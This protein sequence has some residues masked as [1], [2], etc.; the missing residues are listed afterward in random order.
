MKRRRVN[1]FIRPHII[2]PQDQYTYQLIRDEKDPNMGDIRA[3]PLRGYNALK[4]MPDAIGCWMSTPIVD[5]TTDHETGLAKPVTLIPFDYDAVC[6][7][8]QN[9]TDLEHERVF[10]SV[11]QW[12]EFRMSL[13]EEGQTAPIKS[14]KPAEKAPETAQEDDSP[15]LRDV[16][17][18]GRACAPLERMDIETLS[19]L[20]CYRRDAIQVVKGVSR[21]ALKAMDAAL[22]ENGLHW[23]GEEDFQDN[24]D[25]EGDGAA[26]DV[27]GDEEDIL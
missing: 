27:D 17:I 15:S 13:E 6:D 9:L 25:S 10:D 20:S 2:Q 8:S 5:F 11:S 22:E 21:D 26:D 14:Q 4:Y 16:G 7:P 24:D 19:D 1:G 12:I 3:I 18:S 23:L